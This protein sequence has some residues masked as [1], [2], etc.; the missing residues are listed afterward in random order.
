MDRR[1][2]G[3]AVG[4]N[5]VAMVAERARAAATFMVNDESKMMTKNG[6]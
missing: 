4:E 3:T 1:L 5:A 2:N 6:G